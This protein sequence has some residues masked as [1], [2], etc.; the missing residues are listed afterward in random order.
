MA[1]QWPLVAQRL[2]DLLPTLPGWDQV[3]VFDGPPITG[4]DPANYCTVG[5][6]EDDQAGTYTTVQ[7]PDGF[8]RQESGEVRSQLVCRTGEDNL[9]GMRALLFGL[10]DALDAAI[11]D[12]RRLGVLSPQGTSDLVVD[13]LS[14]QNEA[15]TAQAV[16]IAL[17]YYTVT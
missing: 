2:V 16:V 1:T 17:Q 3:S 11:R 13:V 8:Q 5:Y 14:V 15:G 7:D 4:D 10:I 6:V 12:D 9:S